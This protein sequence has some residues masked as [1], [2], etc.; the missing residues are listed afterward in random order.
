MFKAAE[1]SRPP[2]YSRHSLKTGDPE[3]RA[4]RGALQCTGEAREGDR[5]CQLKHMLRVGVG[6]M[7]G[8]YG[9]TCMMRV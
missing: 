5:C 4:D 7:G 9:E 3:Q 2:Q 6:G 1:L 8:G